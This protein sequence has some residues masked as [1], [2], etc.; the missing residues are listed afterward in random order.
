MKGWRVKSRSLTVAVALGLVLAGCGGGGSDD[1]GGPVG[2]PKQGGTLTYAVNVET[3]SL[4]PAFCTLSFDRCAPIFGTLLRYDVDKQQFVGQMAESFESTDG[5]SWT[6]KL[7]DGVTFSD[8]TPYDAEAVVYNWDR[9]KDPK[10][11]APSARYTQ[12]L[13]WKV[14]DPL[15][16]AVTSEVPNF[17]LPWALTQGLSTIGSPKAIEAAG[18]DIANSPV[19]AGPFVLDKWTRNSQAEYS[20]NKTYFE[21]GLPYLDKLVIKVI[22]ADDQRLNALRSGEIDV[23]WSLLTKDAKAIDSEG[24]YDIYRVPLN[25]GT[26]LQFNLKDPV[27][28]DEGLRQALLSAFDSAQINNAVYPGDEPVDA[29]LRPDSPYRDDALGKF[30]EKDLDEAQRLFD[31]YLERTGKTSETVTFLCYAGIPAL[32]QVAQLIQSQMSKIE[33]LEFKLEPV[34]GATL[35]QRSTA[36]DFQTIMGA[37]LS[38]DMDRLYSVFHTDAPLNVMGYSNPTVDEALD[39]TRRSNDPA[40]VEKA[41][42]VVNGELSKDGP[43]RNWRYQTGHLFANDKVQG[44][45]LAGTS[46]GASAYWQYAWLNE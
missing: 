33:G 46:S 7:R 31:D 44:I 12:G 40:E 27:V 16:V 17:Q 24:G 21:E 2:E 41:Y 8:G 28:S 20:R 18:E 38:Q 6:L 22:G 36:R 29:F 23:D 15:T 4:D 32:E 34:D 13:T 39:T 43:L 11:L 14:V 26:G 19:G 37:S 9:I 5:K 10:T 1:D 35:S 3:V 25:G 30:P 45:V 42:Q